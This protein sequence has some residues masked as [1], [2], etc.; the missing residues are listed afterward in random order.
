MPEQ[1]RAFCLFTAFS[2]TVLSAA[3]TAR[4]S[5]LPA[6]AHR[7]ALSHAARALPLLLLRHGG[8]E[9]PALWS[10]SVRTAARRAVSGL[11]AC[12][13]AVCTLLLPQFHNKDW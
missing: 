1:T 2:H 8:S 3:A 5:H 6:A 7:A 13:R 9:P 10:R 4:W 11:P 12:P